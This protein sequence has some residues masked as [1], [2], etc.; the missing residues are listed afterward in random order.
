MASMVMT[1]ITHPGQVTKLVLDKLRNQL[2]TPKQLDRMME[3]LDL[4][5]RT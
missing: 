3:I 1:F 2:L 5:T 4:K